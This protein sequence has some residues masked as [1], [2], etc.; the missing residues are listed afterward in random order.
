MKGKPHK[1]VSLRGS[2]LFKLTSPVRLAQILCIPPAQLDRL[3][4]RGNTNYCVRTDR[5]TE[6][7]IEEPKALLKQVH[8]RV[9]HLLAQVETPAY[10]HSG[11]KKHSYITNAA[12]HRVEGGAVKL[13]VQKFFPS[14]RAAAVCHFFADVM[15]YPMD[16]ASRMTKLLTINGHLPTGGNASCILS[17]WAYK[18]MFDEIAALAA[19]KGCTFTLYVDDMT[20]TGQFA[21]RAMQKEARAIIGRYRLKAHK[22][23]IFS[24]R[25][26]R[27]VTG[28]AIT[29]RGPELPNRRARKIA[30][31]MAGVEAAATDS[32]RL[33]LMPSLIGRVSEAVEVDPLWAGRKAAAVGMRRTIRSRVEKSR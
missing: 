16:V 25:Q 29:A 7:L 23:K 13:D 33:A 9:A 15:E 10:L 17:F 19:A 8:A 11:I 14:V 1:R 26:P 31:T 5:K 20:I 3:L 18:N 4:R 6:R 22:T 12:E 28:V 24:H 2:A 21:T 27:I 30:I 32:Q